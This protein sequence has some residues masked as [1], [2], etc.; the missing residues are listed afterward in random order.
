MRV[1]LEIGERM[2][3]LLGLSFASG[4]VDCDLDWAFD[5]IPSFPPSVTRDWTALGCNE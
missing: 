1:T 3:S 5:V 4:H 2:V